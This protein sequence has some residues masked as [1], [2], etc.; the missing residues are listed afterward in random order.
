MN[1]FKRVIVLDLDETLIH[2]YDNNKVQLMILRP[3][4]DKLMDKLQ[5]LKE[6]NIDIILCT[7]SRNN[8]VNRFFELKPRFKTVFDKVYT[9]DNEEEWKNF[10]KDS[11]PLEYNA[12]CKNINLEYLKP[13]TTFG[14]DQILYI[15]DNK[16]EEVRLKILFELTQGKLNKDVTFFTG[17]KFYRK[18]VI[19][20][21]MLD[22][23][24]GITLNLNLRQKLEEYEELEQLNPGCNMM[25]SAI[26]SFVNKPFKS[27]LLA[28]DE[29]YSNYYKQYDEKILKLEQE[30]KEIIKYEKI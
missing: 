3:N 28:I 17:F 22:Y 16:L 24:N 4:I 11:Y 10:N 5:K 18:S 21:K 29:I 14:Y 9:R 30:I 23:I 15:D 6:Q 25:I 7:T 20:E 19:W 2:G 26:E 13:V 27:G 12:R 1:H 8:W